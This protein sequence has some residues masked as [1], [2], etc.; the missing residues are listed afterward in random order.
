MPIMPQI[1]CVFVLHRELHSAAKTNRMTATAHR[2]SEYTRKAQVPRTVGS[3][4][5]KKV[6]IFQIFTILGSYIA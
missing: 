4:D 2:I 1:A 5:I 6:K 3:S